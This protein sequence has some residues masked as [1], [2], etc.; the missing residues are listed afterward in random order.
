MAALAFVVLLAPPTPRMR[1]AASTAL[2]AN[3]AAHR[4]ITLIHIVVASLFLM[5]MPLQFL[6]RIRKRHIAVH[7][8]SGRLLVFLGAVMGMSA[9]LM[10]FAMNIGGASETAATTL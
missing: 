2:D 10:S 8:W 6:E 7:R 1:S 3:F 9:L 4:S 5:L